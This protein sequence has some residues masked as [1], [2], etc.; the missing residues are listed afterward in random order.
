VLG[1]LGRGRVGGR[2]GNGLG[3]SLGRRVIDCAIGDL[4]NN[5]LTWQ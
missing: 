2:L 4:T 1:L 5:D 3:V